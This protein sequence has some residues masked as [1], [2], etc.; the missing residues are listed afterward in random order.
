M[1]IKSEQISEV[2]NNI[3]DTINSN[4]SDD[5]FDKNT[6]S[7]IKHTLYLVESLLRGNFKYDTFETDTLLNNIMDAI[8][9]IDV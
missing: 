3:K 9:N 7:L 6:A 5:Y 8:D 2:L 4:Y 1:I